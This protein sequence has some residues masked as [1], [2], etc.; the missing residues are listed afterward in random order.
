[1]QTI[2]TANANDRN[3]QSANA[4]RV[5][6]LL[7]HPCGNHHQMK[8]YKNIESTISVSCEHSPMFWL[9]DFLE[10]HNSSRSSSLQAGPS[11]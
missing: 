9:L 8:R 4:K 2:G 3:G 5:T 6:I 10:Y 1:M 7:W 11:S